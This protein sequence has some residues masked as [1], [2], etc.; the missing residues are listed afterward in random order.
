MIK[1]FIDYL[2]EIHFEKNP[3]ILDDDLSDHFD[4]WMG[5]I[6]QDEMIKYADDFARINVHRIALRI[7]TLFCQQFGIEY[8]GELTQ[9]I[10]DIIL[11]N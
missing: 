4:N 2:Q 1:T 11:E 10:K 9:E 5:D 8:D 3:M 6:E 7:E